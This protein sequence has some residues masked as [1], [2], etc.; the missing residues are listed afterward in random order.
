MAQ[1]IKE[2]EVEVSKP[3]F[4]QAI[5]AKQFD[6]GS[7]YLRVTLVDNDEKIAVADT[8]SVT[9][10]ARRSD[11]GESKFV[12]EVDIGKGTVLVPLTYWMLELE[13][14]VISDV[15]I[16]DTS[17]NILTTTSFTIEVE[18][19]SCQD[20]DV[21]EDDAKVD[22]L[23]QLILQVQDVKNNYDVVHTYDPT[24]TIAISGQGVALAL[25][26]VE[27]DVDTS[28]GSGSGSAITIS[29]IVESTADGGSNVVTFSDGTTLTVKNGSKGSSGADGYTPVKG[30]DYFTEADKA[31]I[32]EEIKSAADIP[33]YV[34]TEAE[35]IID[36]IIS[37]QG[38]RT[39]TFAAITD[40]HYGN[41]DYTDGI[42]HACQAMKYI[43]ER[44][45]LDAVAILGDYTD[46][47][48]STDITDAMG[49]FKNINALLSELR[50][51]PNIRQMGNHD[52]YPDNIPITRRLIQYHSDDVVWGNKN[53][54]YFH[55]DF[56]DYKLRVI[57]PNTN[58]NNPI[59]SSNNKPNSN[60][61]ISTEQIN[62]LIQTLDLSDKSDAEEWG[63]LILSH[64]PL[65]YWTSDGV[66][67]LGAI[68]NA[69][70]S[71]S[72]WSD[73]E[74][75]C[76]FKG[77]N[78]ASLIGNIHGH[79]HNLLTSYMFIGSPNNGEYSQVYR[80][81]VPNACYDRENQYPGVW[82]ETTTYSKTQN[83]AKNTSFVVF[84]I[85][86]DTHIINAVC[87]G[88][89]YDRAVNYIDGTTTVLYS[90]EYN[91]TDVTSSNTATSIQSGESYSTTLTV[92][93]E[94]DTI[95]ITMGGVD[96]TST[97]YDESTGVI[98]ID[99][100][101]GNIVITASATVTETEE[102]VN[103]LDT[104]GY[105]DGVRISSSS[106]TETTDNAEGCFAT[107]YIDV[108]EI[109]FTDEEDDE[110]T[111][112]IHIG[113]NIYAWGA[114]FNQ[115]N[116]IGKCCVAT[117]DENKGYR[118]GGY[119]NQGATLDYLKFNFTDDNILVIGKNGDSIPKYI[120]FSGVGSGADAVVTFNQ[121]PT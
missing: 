117:Y 17:G 89:G 48:P 30:T 56:E 88:A 66:Y 27:I 12:G 97:V 58:E 32:V 109:A 51:A 47:Y 35:S 46:G 80:Y 103:L 75:S 76:D 38:N 2:I 1:V 52:Y 114:D 24:S 115:S 31:E 9:I 113:K 60:V 23:T 10:N 14:K 16:I 85:D 42:K 13:G 36:R 112:E 72:S 91:L 45:K 107:G 8:S 79:L 57:C 87:Y 119:I 74:I 61:S 34:I 69:Y 73:S 20:S 100:V 108:S 78:T 28:G 116:N 21:S 95:A 65:D 19:A 3:N 15:S 62:W 90:V 26:Q 121:L 93:G 118:E 70:K 6:Y 77:K 18:R 11:G 94:L 63:I 55:K 105:T 40:M 67:R 43:D 106:G 81:C 82:G 86:L 104:V 7:R 120:R 53:G 29:S 96:V 37:A 4:F 44:I 110:N 71:G 41:S 33:D 68:L 102:I 84:C 101:T 54:G 99:E 98:T 25:K 111:E 92:S 49:D 39:F 22:V 50:F 83:S 64:Q 5:I 59:D